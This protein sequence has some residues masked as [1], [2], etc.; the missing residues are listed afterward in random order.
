MPSETI[1]ARL[2]V[3]IKAGLVSRSSLRHEGRG[4]RKTPIYFANNSGF[5]AYAARVRVGKGMKSTL[6]LV[7][8]EI[9]VAGRAFISDW[10]KAAVVDRGRRKAA[11]QRA[12]LRLIRS[13]QKVAVGSSGG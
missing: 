12:V 11:S 13:L 8:N 5:E 4:G 1:A 7:D 9:L 2:R 6:N 3:L 10:R